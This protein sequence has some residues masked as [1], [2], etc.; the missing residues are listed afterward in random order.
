MGTIN[1]HKRSDTDKEE[2][3]A[4]GTC[5]KYTHLEVR[6]EGAEGHES[7]DPPT[8]LQHTTSSA[9]S[10]GPSGSP[11]LRGRGHLQP[12]PAARGHV[13]CQFAER[14]ENGRRVW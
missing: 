13:T 2:N 4:P 14:D 6:S 3:I 12:R 8:C 11:A 7:R 9:G 1:Y 5:Q 10:L